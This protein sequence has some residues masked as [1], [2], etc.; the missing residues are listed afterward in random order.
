MTGSPSLRELTPLQGF[1]LG[2]GAAVVGLLPWLLTGLQAPRLSA[3][4]MPPDITGALL[5]LIPNALVLLVGIVMLPGAIAGI[6]L[7]GRTA[8][9][10]GRA[11]W[12]A[13]GGLVLVFGG[14]VAQSL[15]VIV[16]R[17]RPDSPFLLDVT[18][19]AVAVGILLV[20][21]A[22]VCHVLARGS[23]PAATVAVAGAAVAAGPGLREALVQLSPTALQGLPPEV[24]TTLLQVVAYVPV[25]LTGFALA[26]CGW[27][28]ARRL[29]AWVVALL[30]LWGGR[31]ALETL[32]IW[33][34][35]EQPLGMPSTAQNS[36]LVPGELTQALIAG[37]PSAVTALVVGVVGGLVVARLRRRD[38]EQA[39]TVPAA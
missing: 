8:G 5:P 32:Q 33:L 27:T 9:S 39:D 14:A 7:R 28:P 29:G 31:A 13:T 10:N 18:V 15:A 34:F 4:Q 22:V 25:V 6:L 2:A 12:A 20:L 30:L 17:L 21:S 36:A 26:W 37:L 11:A 24:T 35:W 16:P 1:L 38:R 3:P 19:S 23:V